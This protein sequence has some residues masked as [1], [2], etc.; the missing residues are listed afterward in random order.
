[1]HPHRLLTTRLAPRD[2]AVARAVPLA[3][4]HADRQRSRQRLELP[5]GAV[6]AI[7][8]PGGTV[9]KP[10]DVLEVE[11]GGHPG[12][13]VVARPQA[14]M[15]AR[16]ADP[17]ALARAAWHLGNRHCRV[18]IETDRLLLEPDPVLAAMLTT[19]GAQVRPV[20]APF[21][22]E[23]GAYGGG[24]KHGH[25]ASFAEDYALA[26]TSFVLYDSPAGPT[27]LQSPGSHSHG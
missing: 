4:D 10:G 7:A 24:H 8:L 17:L 15:E 11:G 13:V 3:L 25:D 2:A 9:L 19:L 27:L 5:D 6:L 16:M 26:Q 22:P 14:L 21:T 12:F 20:H 23:G 1:M 18:Q